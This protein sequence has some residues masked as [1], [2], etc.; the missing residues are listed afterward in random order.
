MKNLKYFSLT[1]NLKK[2]SFNFIKLDIFNIFLAIYGTLSIFY[3][4]F[5]MSVSGKIRNL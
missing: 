1:L 4:K 2:K 5:T 3:D